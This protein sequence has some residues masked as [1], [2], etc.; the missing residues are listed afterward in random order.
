MRCVAI[1][2]NG[3]VVDV[4]PQPGTTESCTLVL[5]TPGEIGSSPWNLTLAQA[6]P[7]TWAIAGVLVV[8]FTFRM[9]IRALP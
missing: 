3:F 7:L 5:A 2:V 4:V 6:E 9:L 8:A 1:D